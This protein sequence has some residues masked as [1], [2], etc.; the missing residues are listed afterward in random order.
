MSDLSNSYGL[1]ILNTSLNDL[2]L[3]KILNLKLLN[4]SFN[5][6]WKSNDKFY[7]KMLIEQNNGILNKNLTPYISTY[8]VYNYLNLPNTT[9]FEST[10][11]YL[12][13]E[14]IFKKNFKFISTKKT[15]KRRL[16][17]N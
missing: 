7:P 6:E 11:T 9:F 2:K 3:K 1:F 15:N 14:G 12:N 10:G 8:N 13:T 4:Y 17:N 5:K 16:A